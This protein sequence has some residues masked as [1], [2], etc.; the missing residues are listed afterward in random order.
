MKVAFIGLGNMGSAMAR[1][2]LRAG[3][4]LAVY[5]RAATIILRA[6]RIDWRRP[7]RWATD[8]AS[9][10]ARSAQ[11]P[12]AAE[13]EADIASARPARRRPRR[14]GGWMRRGLGVR[15]RF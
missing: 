5:N 10:A 8:P 15:P 1:N 6:E 3:H 12:T 4:D 11:A 2:L 13:V 7:P 9:R 14:A